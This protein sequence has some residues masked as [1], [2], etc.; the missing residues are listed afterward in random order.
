MFRYHV[1]NHK[2]LGHAIGLEH[3]HQRPDMADFV[4]YQP[5]YLSGFPEAEIAV[6]KPGAIGFTPSMDLDDRMNRV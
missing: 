4:V 5:H 1:P 6:M 3:E 2:L